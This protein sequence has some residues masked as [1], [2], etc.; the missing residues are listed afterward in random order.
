MTKGFSRIRTKNWFYPHEQFKLVRGT[1]SRRPVAFP[2][3]QLPSCCGQA[4]GRDARGVSPFQ[5]Y[6]RAV[7]CCANGGDRM[8][9]CGSS[10]HLEEPHQSPHFHRSLHVLHAGLPGF[11]ASAPACAPPRSS[12]R[13]APPCRCVPRVCALLR[14]LCVECTQENKPSP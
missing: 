8:L 3:L 5:Y 4:N 10:P 11:G 1:P 9:C 13:F 2:P 14:A 6:G 7:L 12:G